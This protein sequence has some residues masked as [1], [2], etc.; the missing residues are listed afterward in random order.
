M[1]AQVLPFQPGK[2][3]VYTPDLSADNNDFKDIAEINTDILGNYLER[4]I[5][6]AGCDIAAGGY[7]E[8]RG[9]YR[10]S[11]HFGDSEDARTVHLGLD[12]WCP[13]GT[14][15][16]A[17]EN[18]ELHSFADNDNFGDYGPTLIL[19]HSIDNQVFYTLYGHLSRETLTDKKEGRVFA[20]GDKIAE[21]GSPPTNGDWPPH[22]HFQI[23][24]DMLGKKGD[25]PGVASPAESKRFLDLCPNPKFIIDYR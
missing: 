5:R 15:V 23:I 22:L 20:K 1:F 14:P 2:T 12:V 25:F 13:A 8:N 6:E 21:I 10:K 9:I 17:P 16:F 4:K 7:G 24:S 3:K 19:R 11:K 18:A